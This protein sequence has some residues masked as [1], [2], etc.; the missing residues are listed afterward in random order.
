MK[1]INLLLGLASIIVICG[2]T[3]FLTGELNGSLPTSPVLVVNKPE[4][5]TTDSR[6]DDPNLRDANNNSTILGPDPA[7]KVD[8]ESTKSQNELKFDLSSSPKVD[9]NHRP[10]SKQYQAYLQALNSVP[11]PRG[12]LLIQINSGAGVALA[13]RYHEQRHASK[14]RTVRT[15]S[16]SGAGSPQIAMESAVVRN[17]RTSP[18]PSKSRPPG[19]T[20]L[21]SS[22][23]SNTSPP[24]TLTTARTTYGKY[25]DS[26]YR[27]P[28]GNHFVQ[29]HV[30]RNG[31]VVQG[32]FRTNPDKSYS[33]NWS[34]KGNVNPYTGRKGT[35]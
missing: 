30:R 12:R 17:G 15:F 3:I 16:P 35:R 28:V 34:S 18:H 10:T 33:N 13:N 7:Y 14:R 5:G 22:Q 26:P 11:L 24:S 20:V 4:N 21:S 29:S 6:K 2:L 25:Y 23:P 31:T 27:P 32:H 8:P 19:T 9:Q 1:K